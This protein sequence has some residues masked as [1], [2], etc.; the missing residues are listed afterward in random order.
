MGLV[1]TVE[2]VWKNL[3]DMATFGQTSTSTYYTTGWALRKGASRFTL[4]V[5]GIVSRLSIYRD[6][7]R[8]GRAACDIYGIIYSDSGGNPGTL[9]SYTPSTRIANNASAGWSNLTFTTPVELTAGDYWLGVNCDGASAGLAIYGQTAGGDSRKNS[10]S[11]PPASSY[12]AGTD[13]TYIYCVY[14]TYIPANITLTGASALGYGI[15]N[16]S[17]SLFVTV[18]PAARTF[19]TTPVLTGTT[20]GSADLTRT[21]PTA[22][23]LT[24][25]L[26]LSGVIAGEAELTRVN[27]SAVVA[28]SDPVLAGI[29]SGSATLL[30]IEPPTTLSGSATLLTGVSSCEAELTVGT[31]NAITLTAGSS[32]G[33]SNTFDD[34]TFDVGAFYASGP[35][36]SAASVTVG[37]PSSVTMT[38][39]STLTGGTLASATIMCQVKIEPL[40]QQGILGMLYY[41]QHLGY[42]FNKESAYSI[43]S[44]SIA[45]LTG[46]VS[47]EAELE[48]VDPEATTLTAASPLTGVASAAS[49]VTVGTTSGVTMTA[50]STLTATG[51]F[52]D[53]AFDSAAFTTQV[54]SLISSAASLTTFMLENTSMVN[55]STL[56]GVTGGSA[57]LT[58]TD[59]PAVTLTSGPVLS[60]TLSTTSTIGVTAPT[61]VTSTAGTVLAGVV[62]SNAT[63]FMTLPEAITILA[64]SNLTN[65]LSSSATMVEVP[66][67]DVAASTLTGTVSSYAT[68]VERWYKKFKHAKSSQT[69]QPSFTQKVRQVR[70]G[71]N[72]TNRS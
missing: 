26:V 8:A 49:S 50:A 55:A 10:D 15:A 68:I 56:T 47:G 63:V 52:D 33:G 12:G 29:T 62:A 38:A 66:P 70:R 1:P 69:E 9:V 14:A 44:F 46:T 39:A 45:A 58:S 30:Y 2:T 43:T 31:A 17:N 71:D 16:S 61:A 13:G 37:T 21:L 11:P 3:P 53:V 72:V 7:R 25:A 42:L 64:I 51:T 22:T 6:N 19:T 5:D 59:P 41:D 48:T 34:E 20:S 36:T 40:V 27:P 24:S 23:T 54:M 57:T 28:T 4:P 65:T 60:Y 35:I 67:V 18:I 32:I